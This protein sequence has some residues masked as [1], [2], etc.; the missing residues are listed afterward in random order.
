M[1]AGTKSSGNPP[2]TSKGDYNGVAHER[3]KAGPLPNPLP[4]KPSAREVPYG[5]R[6][7]VK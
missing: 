6:D 2:I 5:G 7:R 4:T 3:P 1:S